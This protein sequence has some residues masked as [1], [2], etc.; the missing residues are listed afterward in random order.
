M[1]KLEQQSTKKVAQLFKRFQF[2]K[3]YKSSLAPVNLVQKKLCFT[4]RVID[5]P[6]PEKTSDEKILGY[7]SSKAAVGA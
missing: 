3:S 4:R 5:R 1:K 2:I 7:S 6:A